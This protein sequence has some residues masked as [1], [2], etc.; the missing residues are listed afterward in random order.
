[1]SNHRSKS[2]N[3]LLANPALDANINPHAVNRRIERLIQIH[4]F[5]SEEAR[6]VVL[7]RLC[8]ECGIPQEQLLDPEYVD[9][10]EL[11]APD[12]ERAY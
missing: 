12:V 4:R 3:E 10:D 5:S 9:E 11:S 2:I 7:K 1:M 8:N 6:T